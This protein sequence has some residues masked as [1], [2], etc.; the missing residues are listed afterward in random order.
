MTEEGDPE[1]I[2][3]AQG[4]WIGECSQAPALRILRR[5]FFEAREELLYRN[6]LIENRLAVAEQLNEVAR[7]IQRISSDV[8]SI[9]RRRRGWRRRSAARCRSSIS[10]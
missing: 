4:D 3:R 10:W 7:L 9:S 8:S 6:R 5:Y 2:L 1:K